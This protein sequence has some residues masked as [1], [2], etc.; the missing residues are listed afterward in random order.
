LD[1]FRRR[2]RK[3]SAARRAVAHEP[4]LD[5][6]DEAASRPTNAAPSEARVRISA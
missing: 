4:D 1:Q 5:I 6:G 2:S 3:V